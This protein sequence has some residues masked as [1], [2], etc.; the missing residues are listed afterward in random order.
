[1]SIIKLQILTE[2]KYHTILYVFRYPACFPV[3]DSFMNL[4]QSIMFVWSKPDL[5]ASLLCLVI[6]I[7]LLFWTSFRFAFNVSWLEGSS[8]Q[9][10]TVAGTSFFASIALLIAYKFRPL[11]EEGGVREQAKPNLKNNKPDRLMTFG[12]FLTK[13]GKL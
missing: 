10:L 4:R 6:G 5:R 9:Y 12:F 8:F 3:K 2:Y 11:S 13:I 7:A 1:M